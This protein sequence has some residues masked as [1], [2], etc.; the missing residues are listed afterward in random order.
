MRTEQLTQ[1]SNP[2][3]GPRMSDSGLAAA[4]WRFRIDMS[5]ISNARFAVAAGI[6]AILG[7]ASL[8]FGA[9]LGPG[10]QRK[11]QEQVLPATQWTLSVTPYG[12]LPGLDGSTTVKGRTTN[13][14][15]DPF[16]VL[17]HL[18]GVPLMGYAEARSGRL[19]LYSDIVYAP[20]AVDASSARSLCGLTLDAAL[21][22]DIEETIAEVGAVYEIAK[23]WSGS[24]GFGRATALDLLAGARYW[25]LDA[26]INLALT[27]TL[28]TAGLSLSGGRAIA[29]SGGVDWVD[30]VV[31]LR[32]RHQLAPGQE[33]VL[34]GD[35]GGFD[36][37]SQFTWNVLAAYSWRIGTHFGATYSG[38]LG[39]RALGVDYEQGS[40]VNRF[41]Y[42]VIQ[43]GPVLGLTVNF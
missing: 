30:P 8:A 33:L 37:G 2:T 43:H 28:N 11:P 21:G 15:V 16:Q 26:S 23:W 27:G 17:E 22:V 13:L 7:S 35:I 20:L 10:P 39:Y 36:V 41:E 40:G 32:L 18:D 24:G 42:D 34:R 29:R 25:H 4:D 9:D 38:M 19:G 31:G 6:C 14:S 5:V 3:S 1:P 12:W